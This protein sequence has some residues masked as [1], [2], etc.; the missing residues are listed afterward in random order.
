MGETV[1]S[2]FAKVRK[3]PSCSASFAKTALLQ[4]CL[5][6]RYGKPVG[7]HLLAPVDISAISITLERAAVANVELRKRFGE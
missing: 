6:T 3:E 1:Y 2:L 4:I 5:G 7:C